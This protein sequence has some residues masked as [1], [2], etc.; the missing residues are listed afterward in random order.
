MSK[1]SNYKEGRASGRQQV[2]DRWSER[3]DDIAGA[4]PI[5]LESGATNEFPARLVPKD[6]RDRYV[7][8]KELA[9]KIENEKAK[10]AGDKQ[11]VNRTLTDADVDYAQRKRNI[12][13]R[14]Q[15]DHW[16]TQS[17]DLNDPTQGK[18]AVAIPKAT[19]KITKS[20]STRSVHR[21]GARRAR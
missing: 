17:I 8:A 7:E 3:L 12:L 15:Y 14:L 11:V 21:K 9:Y 20:T 6:S 18:R 19:K 1:I 13:N 16:L 2:S 4:P 5:S 10:S